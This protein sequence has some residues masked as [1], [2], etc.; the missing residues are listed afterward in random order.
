M[1]VECS[2][3]MFA[4]FYWTVWQ[5]TPEDRSFQKGK[6]NM[7]SSKNGEHDTEV[8]TTKSKMEIDQGRPVKKPCRFPANR[9]Q[10]VNDKNMSFRSL[11]SK[12]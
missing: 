6:K 7:S 12:K 9:T 3:K 5:H 10:N 1:E 11:Q 8:P 2:P 4:N